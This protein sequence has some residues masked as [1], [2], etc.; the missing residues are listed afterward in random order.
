MVLWL[1]FNLAETT[2][3]RARGAEANTAEAQLG[4]SSCVKADWEE[5]P[6]QGKWKEAKHCGNQDSKNKRSRKLMW[7]SLRFQKTG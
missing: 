2:P 6:A 1:R 5:N 4:E 3:A 7:L